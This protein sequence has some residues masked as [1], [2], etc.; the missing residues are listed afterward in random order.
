MTEDCVNPVNPFLTRR[1]GFRPA[2][3]TEILSSLQELLLTK[4]IAT[5]YGYLCSP[6]LGSFALA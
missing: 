3:R 6:L 5:G 1:P 2:S 4:L